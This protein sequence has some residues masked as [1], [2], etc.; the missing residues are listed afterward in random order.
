VVDTSMVEGAAA[1]M[2]SIYGAQQYGF[3]SEERGNNLLDSGAPFYEVYETSDG[4]WVSI[5]SIEPQFYASLI[6]RLGLG[7]EELPAQMDREHWPAFKERLSAIFKTRTRDEWCTVFEDSDACFAPVLKMSEAYLHPHNLARGTFVE[8]NGARQPGPA[9]RFSRTEAGIG[10][11]PPK[12]GEHSDEVLAAA[13]YSSEE[14]AALRA[15]GSV[16]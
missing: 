15:S 6:E 2:M 9:P 3:W 4:K 1:L 14:I 5:G 11:P 8:T 7:D 13:G 12:L 10:T 16:R